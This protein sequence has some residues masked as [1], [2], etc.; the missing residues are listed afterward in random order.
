MPDAEPGKNGRRNRGAASAIIRSMAVAA[1]TP[2]DFI[3]VVDEASTKLGVLSNTVAAML[4]E[5]PADRLHAVV[6]RYRDTDDALLILLR[7][8]RILAMTMARERLLREAD[9]KGI[10][11]LEP[12]RLTPADRKRFYDAHLKHYEE[13]AD[14]KMDAPQVIL[15]LKLRPKKVERKTAP[16]PAAGKPRGVVARVEAPPAA[17]TAPAPPRAPDITIAVQPPSGGEVNY[18]KLRYATRGRLVLLSGTAYAPGAK[19]VL[20]FHERGPNASDVSGFGVVGPPEGDCV[21]VSPL[22]P[23]PGFTAV[24]DELAALF[25]G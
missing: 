20:T 23:S 24:M 22:E 25:G 2:Y 8:D 1:N 16:A 19:L 7:I 17:P 12:D 3:C 18:C 6:I 4:R 21:S 11:T 15:G 13:I 14:C 5:I 9:R 10:K